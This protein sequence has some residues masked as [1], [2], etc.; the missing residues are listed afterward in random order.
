MPSALLRFPLDKLMAVKTIIC[1]GGNCPDGVASAI[2]LHD[3]L[4]DAELKFV[5][6]GTEEQKALRATSGMLFADFSPHAET[7]QKFVDAGAIVLDHH[8][9]VSPGAGPLVVSQEQF[10]K[11]FKK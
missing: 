7:F 1:H 10:E 8:P 5:Q 2:L 11:W 4:P 3:V 9:H 6:Y